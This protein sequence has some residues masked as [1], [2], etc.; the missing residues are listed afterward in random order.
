[1]SVRSLRRVV[2]AYVVVGA[3]ALT[4][5]GILPFSGSRPRLLGLPF[6]IF[7]VALWAVLCF[8]VLAALERAVSRAEDENAG[9]TPWNAGN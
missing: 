9:E 2:V 1:M 6:N 3:I 4:W 7:W 8:I 5:P